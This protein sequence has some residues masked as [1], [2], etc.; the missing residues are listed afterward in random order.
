M[1][2]W[3]MTGLDDNFPIRQVLSQGSV[4]VLGKLGSVFQRKI[5]AV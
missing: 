3:C 2:G 5:C 1:G 4:L